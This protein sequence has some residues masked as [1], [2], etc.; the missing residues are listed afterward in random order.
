[1]RDVA[2][3]VGENLR[4]ADL[5]VDIAMRVTIDPI[6]DIRIRDI[7]A[8]LYRESTID[9]ASSKFLCCTLLRRH[10]VRENDLRFR[11]AL[12]YRFADKIEAALVFGVEVVRCETMSVV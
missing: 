7:I 5:R 9:C 8:Q 3:L 2:E 6:V 11:L 12:L 4:L 1:M 10:M